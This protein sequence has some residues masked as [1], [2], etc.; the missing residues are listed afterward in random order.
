MPQPLQYFTGKWKAL[1]KQGST[2][3]DLNVGFPYYYYYYSVFTVERFRLIIGRERHYVL[4]NSLSHTVVD[5]NRVGN[6]CLGF[7]SG[8]EI[9]LMFVAKKSVQYELN[10]IKQQAASRN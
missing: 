7:G 2:K 9:V 5:T 4:F 6:L 1:Q 8:K 10:I 3:T